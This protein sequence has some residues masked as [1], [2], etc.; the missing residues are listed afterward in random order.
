MEGVYLSIRTNVESIA[1]M[2]NLI[3]QWDLSM[4]QIILSLESASM[5]HDEYSCLII[6]TLLGFGGSK[7]WKIADQIGLGFGNWGSNLQ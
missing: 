5:V 3:G 7:Y 6:Y 2:S 1:K 4:H